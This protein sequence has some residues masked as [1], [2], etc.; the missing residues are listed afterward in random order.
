MV[1]FKYPVASPL[2]LLNLRTFRPVRN[3]A[4]KYSA[5][6]S[7]VSALRNREPRHPSRTTHKSTLV[8]SRPHPRPSPWNRC[9]CTTSATLVAWR[10]VKWITTAPHLKL[11]VTGKLGPSYSGGVERQ[12][13]VVKITRA[14][15]LR[16]RLR[17][18]RQVT[19]DTRVMKGPAKTTS[20]RC[21]VRHAVS[22]AAG[23]GSI[24]PN[25]RPIS[26]LAGIA[27][28]GDE[29]KDAAAEVLGAV[30]A[31]GGCVERGGGGGTRETNTERETNTDGVC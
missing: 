25:G 15:V 9:A 27:A 11:S 3:L 23:R 6:S 1:D 29:G 7:I 20:K 2:R 16:R 14:K 5:L 21:T 24:A 12:K 28:A 30:Q 17:P 22:T 18:V 19:A 31:G 8:L 4:R 13:V 10:S 26:W